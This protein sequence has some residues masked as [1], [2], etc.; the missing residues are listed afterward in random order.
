VFA[1]IGDGEA[2]NRD[3]GGKMVKM[4]KVRYG[5]DDRIKLWNPPQILGFCGFPPARE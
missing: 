1:C 4:E 3:F 2:K 5:S